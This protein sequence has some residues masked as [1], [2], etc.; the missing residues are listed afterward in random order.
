MNHIS[1]SGDSRRSF[2]TI[3]GWSLLLAC[4][5]VARFGVC[6]PAAAAEPYAEM[7]EGLRTRQWYDTALEYI[8]AQRN[9]PLI[10]EPDRQAMPYEEGRLMV[11]ASRLENDL[12]RRNA[13]LD[14]AH[15]KFS[16]F[17]QSQPGHPLAAVAQTQL[18]GVLVERGRVLSIASE[19]KGAKKE[20]LLAQ[21]RESFAA[22]LPV[23][24][25]A[26]QKCE[27]RYK[28]FPANPN[29]SPEEKAA[30]ERA[31]EDLIRARLATALVTFESAKSFPSG[32]DDRKAMFRKSIDAYGVIYEKYRRLRVG[33]AALVKQA[34]C[35]QELGEF[36]QALSLYKQILDNPEDEHTRELRKLAL[37]H[38]LECWTHDKEKKYLEAIEAGGKWVDQPQSAGDRGEEAAA[39]CYLTGFAMFSYASTLDAKQA[40][41]QR[42][43]MT[44]ARRLA[45]K[46]TRTPNK[47]RERA[48]KLMQEMAGRPAADQSADPATFAECFDRGREAVDAV[49]SAQAGLREAEQRQKPAE[50]TAPLRAE[51]SAN[52]KVALRL[53][54]RALF[55][56]D[57]TVTPEQVLLVQSHLCRL[58]YLTGRY[59]ETGVLGE[60]MAAHAPADKNSR[61]VALMGLDAYR[62][63]FNEA[64]VDAREFERNCMVRLAEVITR[65][66]PDQ[67]EA[68]EAWLMLISVS[69]SEKR[70]DQAL[71]YATHIGE[72]SPRR[73]DADLR[74]GLA[75]YAAYVEAMRAAGSAAPPAASVANLA[76]AKTTLAL[77]WTRVRAKIDEGAVPSAATVRALLALCEIH[78]S[79]GEVEPALAILNDPKAGPLALL[80]AQSPAVADPPL[81]MEVYKQALIVQGAARADEQVVKLLAEAEK[82]ATGAGLIDSLTLAQVRMARD[83]EKQ[84]AAFRER[85][86]ALEFD[87]AAKVFQRVMANIGARSAS[88][89][90]DTKVWAANSYYKMASE[91]VAGGKKLPP[92]AEGYFKQAAELFDRVLAEAPSQANLDPDRLLAIRLQ[93]ALSKR[94]TGKF[95]EAI[96]LLDTVLQAK[97]SLMSVQMAAAQ[98]FQER[99]VENA[100]YY[101]TAVAGARPTT[102]AKGKKANRIWGWAELSRRVHSQLS[103]GGQRDPKL[104]DV[105]HEARLNMARCKLLEGLAKQGQARA[106]SFELAEKD[107][108]ATAQL[109]PD[110][111]GDAWRPKYN[112]LYRE[113]Q[114]ALNRAPD[115]LPAEI[116]DAAKKAAAR[117]AVRP[118]APAPSAGTKQPVDRTSPKTSAQP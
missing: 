74:I 103:R 39:I 99:G 11:S 54:R 20:E 71:E 81:A 56:A 60:Y 48:Q 65:A 52:G 95:G 73:G 30:R 58:F 1:R 27:A 53:L 85:N 80:A 16:E 75:Q 31:Q 67:P 21:A 118:A 111:G 106:K 89:P 6:R 70:L 72:Q 19:R 104:L 110:L 3:F 88:L 23:F 24:A 18:G 50:E 13:L 17:V 79:A 113:I 8:D 14:K 35:Y 36:R 42:R 5:M 108:L 47:Y 64:P 68:D 55:L 57:E 114:I 28:E 2:R 112:D 61:Q 96:D 9:N 26:E 40:E 98:T 22:A 105:F 101:A 90:F 97:E 78:V 77:G 34:E 43:L 91:Y 92:E 45:A 102:D 93:A 109:R 38:A 46:A 7:L 15:A 4:A 76:A 25:A 44:Q 115:G 87:K 94:A 10:P 83:L 32:S 117:Q 66:W 100:G 51:I 33:Q 107:V 116:L 12:A 49:H 86:D 84:L 59:N 62:Q 29:A 63:A 69:I 41:E 82:F 37:Q